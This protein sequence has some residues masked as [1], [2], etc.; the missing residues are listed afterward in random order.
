[1]LTETLDKVNLLFQEGKYVEVIALMTEELCCVKNPS[2]EFS[3]RLLRLRAFLKMGDEKNGCDDASWLLEHIDVA[4]TALKSFSSIEE[5]ILKQEIYRLLA[6]NAFME[7]KYDDAITYY[8]KVLEVNPHF[9]IAYRERGTV[10]YA[11]GEKELAE[12]DMLAYF[13]ENPQAAEELTGSFNAE[14]RE[15]GCHTHQS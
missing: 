14:G 6:R 1:M 13:Q 15:G 7:K 3:V 12:R 9:A 4:S 5:S 11:K 8:N 10:Y 2:D